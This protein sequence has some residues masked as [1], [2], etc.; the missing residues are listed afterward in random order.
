MAKIKRV[1]PLN[2]RLV[3]VELDLTEKEIL[4]ALYYD[5]KSTMLKDEEGK[6]IFK[7]VVST[8]GKLIGQK[9]ISLEV[10]PNDPETS[11][12]FKSTFQ[13]REMR[14]QENVA[15]IANVAKKLTKI[16]GKLK[17]AVEELEEES[18]KIEEV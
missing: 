8:N 11:K 17:N 2:E 5:P 12:K 7:M 6:T 15:L 9:G 14:E 16:E 1:S 13:L 10:D 4:D 18:Q 3:R